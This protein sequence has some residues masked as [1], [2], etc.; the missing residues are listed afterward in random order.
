MKEFQHEHDPFVSEAVSDSICQLQSWDKA[1][2]AAKKQAANHFPQQIKN[3]QGHSL[4]A[5]KAP[6]TD[7]T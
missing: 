3:A 2:L 7:T 1:L 4:L 5:D 6:D